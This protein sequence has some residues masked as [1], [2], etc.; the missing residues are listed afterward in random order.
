MTDVSQLAVHVN[1][2]PNTAPRGSE[3]FCRTYAQQTAVSRIE[4]ARNGNGGGAN[5]FD[6]LR[7][8]QEGDRA[9][10]RCRSGRTN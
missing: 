1:R 10:E 2:G 5:G 6:R 8:E 3:E 9:Y 4:A 7:A